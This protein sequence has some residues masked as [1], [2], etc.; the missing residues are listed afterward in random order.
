[1]SNVDLHVNCPARLPDYGLILSSFS[2]SSVL[3]LLRI[4]VSEAVTAITGFDDM[5]VMWEPIQRGSRGT[6]GVQYLSA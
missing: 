1:V 6:P 5:T 4:G 2:S 3:L